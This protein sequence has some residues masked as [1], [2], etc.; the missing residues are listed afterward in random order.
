MTDAELRFLFVQWRRP[1]LLLVVLLL[2]L[3]KLTAG[4]LPN[5]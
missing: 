1:M 3:L 2:A 5:M 4:D